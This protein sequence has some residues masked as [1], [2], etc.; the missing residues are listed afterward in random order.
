[1]KKII[2]CTMLLIAAETTFCQQ[3]EPTTRQEY[4]AKSKNQRTGAWIL[5]GGGALATGIGAVMLSRSA[6][7]VIINVFGGPA[8][9]KKNETA[10]TVLFVSG[11]AAMAGSIPLFIGSSKNARK[12]ASLSF[13]NERVPYPYKNSL[14]Q[15]SVPSLTLTIRL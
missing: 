1:M 4:L 14:A 3:I 12:A 7:D 15:K 5:L 9:E 6:E 8:P 13:K 2:I 11:L 10:G